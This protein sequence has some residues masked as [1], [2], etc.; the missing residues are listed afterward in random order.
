MKVCLSNGENTILYIYSNEKIR[1]GLLRKKQ[2]HLGIRYFF[3]DR[4]GHLDDPNFWLRGSH[5]IEG[6][7]VYENTTVDL[8]DILSFGFDIGYHW[9]II[10]EFNTSSFIR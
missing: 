1:K 7:S 5:Q 9:P 8:C 3:E 10:I 4:H 2:R 6:V